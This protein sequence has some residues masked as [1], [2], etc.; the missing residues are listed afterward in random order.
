MVLSVDD[1]PVNQAVIEFL[2]E[3]KN[4]HLVQAMDG[5]EA[6]EYLEKAD[7]LP[8]I[9]LL[10]VMMPGLSGYEVCTQ[11]RQ[12]Y[13]ASLPIIMIS[14]KCS[15]EDIVQ[16]LACKCNDYVTKPFDKEELLAR[17]DTH[18]K[19]NCLREI[20][21][22]EAMKKK[23]SELALPR[24]DSIL[25]GECFVVSFVTTLGTGRE[26]VTTIAEKHGLITIPTRLD[27]FYAIAR[28]S[29]SLKPF[30][31]ELIES[32]E[33][34]A[35][36]AVTIYVSKISNCLTEGFGD[37]EKEIVPSTFMYGPGFA[38]HLRLFTI[39]NRGIEL[40]KGFRPSS[41]VCTS[42]IATSIVPDADNIKT[43]ANISRIFF[44]SERLEPVDDSLSAYSV[45]QAE[46][47]P[48]SCGAQP[49][50]AILMNECSKNLLQAIR[51][52]GTSV[53]ESN[54]VF[55]PQVEEI[56]QRYDGTNGP[57]ISSAISQVVDQITAV[58]RGDHETTQ[59]EFD[60]LF[61]NVSKPLR[62]VLLSHLQ[63]ERLRSDIDSSEREYV[64]LVKSVNQN[65]AS[66]LQIESLNEMMFL[67]VQRRV[68]ESRRSTYS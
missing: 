30:F 31:I 61:S 58:L 39:T 20:H 14:A 16:G 37:V 63:N 8:D 17:I 59:C 65:L 6:L 21:E 62:Q 49:A 29:E 2:L 33:S 41:V 4:Y 43:N 55:S 66:I 53:F 64:N 50:P 46:L 68:F 24:L 25:N 32:F 26:I 5:L 9:V 54:C 12:L 47:I 38:D 48:A 11:I 22:N 40:P 45:D 15:R 18:V 19:L 10:D 42:V 27:F 13:P 51:N 56:L 3:D 52:S 34:N 57:E 23:V 35:L 36:Q 60:S 44:A 28:G 67:E 1:D 7:S